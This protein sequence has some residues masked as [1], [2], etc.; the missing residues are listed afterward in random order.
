MAGLLAPRVSVGRL[1]AA[2]PVS[3]CRAAAPCQALANCAPALFGACLCPPQVAA[4]GQLYAVELEGYWMDVGQPKDYLTGVVRMCV[5]CSG[6]GSG[7]HGTRHGSRSLHA[8]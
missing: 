7:A 8:S 2:V 3:F 1:P 5:V 4:D 6:A